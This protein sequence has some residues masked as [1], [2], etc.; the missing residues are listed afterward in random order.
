MNY[1]ERLTLSYD[2]GMTSRY[3]RYILIFLWKYFGLELPPYVFVI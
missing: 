3:E 1:T 2:K